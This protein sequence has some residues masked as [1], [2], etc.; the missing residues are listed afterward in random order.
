[1]HFI[2]KKAFFDLFITRAIAYVRKK[3]YLCTVN[4]MYMDSFEQLCQKRRSIR[5]YTDRPIEQEKIDYLLRCALMSPSAKR[6]CPW[7][8]VVVRDQAKLR[9]LTACRTYGS[10]MFSTATAG[11]VIALDPT[12]CDNT[13]MADGAIAAEHILLA[14]AE[15]GLGACWCHV[16]EREGAPELT[17]RLFNIPEDKVVLCVIALG[18]PDEERQVYD[19][20]KLK[21]DK[22][23]NEKY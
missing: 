16:Y 4:W 10:Q 2:A 18:Y 12:L 9:P 3:P 7:E 21:Y 5:K 15:Q 17:H 11:I 23:H 6:T 14:A 19:T 20:A 8:F 13:W 1:M 22:I